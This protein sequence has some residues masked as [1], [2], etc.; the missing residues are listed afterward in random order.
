[1]FVPLRA[2]FGCFLKNV[3]SFKYYLFVHSS[4][5]TT[6]TIELASVLWTVAFEQLFFFEGEISSEMAETTAGFGVVF[7]IDGVLLKGSQEI[8]NA[9]EALQLLQAHQPRFVTTNPIPTS[10]S[11]VEYLLFL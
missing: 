4:S 2:P 3:S 11:W 7:D 6:S 1:M 10:I 9:K 8:P 5:S